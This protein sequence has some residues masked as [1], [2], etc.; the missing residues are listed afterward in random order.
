MNGLGMYLGLTVGYTPFLDPCPVEVAWLWLLFPVC[1]LVAVGYKTIEMEDLKKMPWE[2]VQF[3]GQIL[4]L[5]VGAA[6]VIWWIAR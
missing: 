2:A 1:L 5:L 4:L 6:G 3:T